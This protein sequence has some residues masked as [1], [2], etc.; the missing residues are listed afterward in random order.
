MLDNDSK[1][2]VIPLSKKKIALLFLGAIAFVILGVW[3][4]INPE[5]FTKNR[6]QPIIFITTV[7]FAAT[8]FFGLC[9]IFIFK[10]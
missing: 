9:A 8:I 4:L 7:G 10:K 2:I 5:T 6:H 1:P 3:F